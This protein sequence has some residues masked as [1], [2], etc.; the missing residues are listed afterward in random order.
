MKAGRPEHREIY[1]GIVDRVQKKKRLGDLELRTLFS[2]LIK[3]PETYKIDFINVHL[4]TLLKKAVDEERDEWLYQHYRH[5]V[6]IPC[7]A[8]LLAALRS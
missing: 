4:L 1:Q 3:L 6:S 2:H 7:L 5:Y 8:G